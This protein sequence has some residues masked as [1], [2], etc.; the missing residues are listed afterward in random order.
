MSLGWRSISVGFLTS[1]HALTL[2][3]EAEGSFKTCVT[4][5]KIKQCHIPD[6]NLMN[7][8]GC[9]LN[10]FKSVTPVILFYCNGP[11]KNKNKVFNT[12]FFLTQVTIVY[13]YTGQVTQ[14][15]T[16]FSILH[17]T[18]QFIYRFTRAPILS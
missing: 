11:L 10:S 8:G 12:Q 14:L 6:H 17:R 4:T 16:K 7:C 2:K 18:Q 9:R 3:V 15:I 13:T 5:Y 1:G